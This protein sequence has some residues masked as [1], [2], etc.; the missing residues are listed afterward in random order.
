M[1]FFICKSLIYIGVYFWL[2]P[3]I[4]V[5]ESGSFVLERQRINPTFPPNLL[6]LNA[7][8]ASASLWPLVA[9][10]G[11]ISNVLLAPPFILD[12]DQVGEIVDQLAVAIDATVASVRR[13]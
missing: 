1:T 13:I 4:N 5:L 8:S 6:R 9:Q 12:D 3:G 10:K 11:G 2:K 7:Y